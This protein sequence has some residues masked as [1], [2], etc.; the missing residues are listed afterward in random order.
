MCVS[1]RSQSAKVLSKGLF[2]SAEVVRGHDWLWGDQDGTLV[3]CFI[4]ID[5]S[6]GGSG[7]T[8]KVI[9]VKDWETDTYVSVGLCMY[10]ALCVPTAQ[11]GRGEVE[12]GQQ[13]EHL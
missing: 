12:Q 7:S 13:A 2:K 11:C 8:G 5:V 1:L 6:L 10:V 3:C 4:A 9:E